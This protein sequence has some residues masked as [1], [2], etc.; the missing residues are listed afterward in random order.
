MGKKTIG[1]LAGVES[2]DELEEN[3]AKVS[4]EVQEELGN[5]NTALF[6]LRNC[7]DLL[8]KMQKITDPAA[9]AKV[10]NIIN[11]NAWSHE[12]TVLVIPYFTQVSCKIT[13][14]V[15]VFSEAHLY[16]IKNTALSEIKL[17]KLANLPTIQIT[18][19]LKKA[20][21]KRWTRS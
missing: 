14:V 5:I 7:I 16:D 10:K 17:K 3:G 6:A 12:L 13:V 19:S 20:T 11:I 15:C 9:K 21:K 4:I 2:N 1:D 8:V 18:M